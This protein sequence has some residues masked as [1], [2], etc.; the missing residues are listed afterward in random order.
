MTF[1]QLSLVSTA[2]MFT[3]CLTLLFTP[4]VI[5]KLFDVEE[6]A[7]A[8]FFT[9]RAAVLFL[10]LSIFVYSLKD[11]N[12]MKVRQS[13]CLSMAVMM[14]SLAALGVLEFMMGNSGVGIFLA[15][16]GELTLGL[17]YTCKYRDY[18]WEARFWES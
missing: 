16:V 5:F 4:M 6:T 11:V 13:V 12:N 2:V 14:L 15:I 9:H 3:L 7:S 8:I 1:K 17:L 10:G 18:G